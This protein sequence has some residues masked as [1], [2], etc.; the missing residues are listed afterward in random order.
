MSL[1]HPGLGNPVILTTMPAWEVLIRIID[2][3]LQAWQSKRW[4]KVEILI[5]FKE[6]MAVSGSN[7]NDIGLQYTYIYMKK[8]ASIEEKIQECSFLV[9][10]SPFL[11]M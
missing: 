9:N 4:I 6:A 7:I 5:S 10:C 11:E 1:G 2:I 3:N 8:K